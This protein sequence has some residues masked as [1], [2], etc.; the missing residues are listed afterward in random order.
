MNDNAPRDSTNITIGLVKLIAGVA[1]VIITIMSQW[2][3]LVVQQSRT[4]QQA[5][6]N[7]RIIQ[8]LQDQLD[9]KMSRDEFELRHRDLQ[10]RV[11]NLEDLHKPK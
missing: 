6:E 11:D 3:Y 7:H 10:H 2:L 1:F 9:G 5:D 4:Q 8:K